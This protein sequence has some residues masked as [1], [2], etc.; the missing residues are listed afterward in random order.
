MVVKCRQQEKLDLLKFLVNMGF[1]LRFGTVC[2][3]WILW[4]LFLTLIF[5]SFI[6]L[7]VFFIQ[8]RLKIIYPRSFSKWIVH[9]GRSVTGIYHSYIIFKR[10]CYILKNIWLLLF[11]FY[12]SLTGVVG[13]GVV[14][15]CAF[16][17]AIL[18]TTV[19]QVSLKN[20]LNFFKRLTLLYWI[21]LAKMASDL[22][23]CEYT[24]R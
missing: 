15:A 6:P 2:I 1:V 14:I 18:G 9:L 17:S 4:V 24:L 8:I 5:G 23:Q 22:Y 19:L 7:P 11:A 12:P 3:V 13:G 10:N 21:Q 16:L 20:S